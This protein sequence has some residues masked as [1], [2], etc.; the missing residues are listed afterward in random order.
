[1]NNGVNFSPPK[2]QTVDIA[3]IL[4]SIR[5]RLDAIERTLYERLTNNS[6]PDKVPREADKE[7]SRKG[8]SCE[9]VSEEK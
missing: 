3:T 5:D 9:K 4:A 1:M 8:C 7:G 2:E 6:G